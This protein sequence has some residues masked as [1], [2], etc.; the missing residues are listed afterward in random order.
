LTVV[1]PSIED[2]SSCRHK[3][4]TIQDGR[5]HG[6]VHTAILA[7]IKPQI[8]SWVCCLR[9]CESDSKVT[10]ATRMKPSAAGAL[11]AKRK[12]DSSSSAGQELH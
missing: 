7:Y 6:E 8:C 1:F 2:A 11:P 3:S 12:A 9:R 4:F 5:L 10:A